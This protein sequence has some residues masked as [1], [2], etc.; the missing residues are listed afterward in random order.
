MTTNEVKSY[1]A[2]RVPFAVQR[3][4]DI[5]ALR[6]CKVDVELDPITDAMVVRLIGFVHAMPG[7]RIRISRRWPKTWWQA[8][9]ERW[10]PKWAKAYWPVDYETLEI[11]KQLF[12]AMCPHIQ[13]DA[14]RDHLRWMAMKSDELGVFRP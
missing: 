9:K 10:L 11:D 14:Q 1:V 4:L 13:D 8:V 5:E 12:T 6:R 3:Y 7:E 2:S